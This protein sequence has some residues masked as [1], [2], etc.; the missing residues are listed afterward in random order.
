MPGLRRLLV[1]TGAAMA[2]H[3]LVL[4]WLQAQWREPEALRPMV[5]PLFTRQ[6]AAA[7]PPWSPT[8]TRQIKKSIK[9]RPLAPVRQQDIASDLIAT[10]V[11][12]EV[13]ESAPVSEA[14][15]EQDRPMPAADDTAS[16][17]PDTPGGHDTPV[18]TEPEP[19]PADTRLTYDLGGY[20]RGDLHGKARVQWQREDARYQVQVTLDFG[21]LLKLVMTSQ[22]E[23]TDDG[24]QP[25]AFE[26]TV[27]GRRRAVHLDAHGITLANGQTLPRPAQVQDA[28]SQFVELAWRF[29]T[30]RERLEEGHTVAL[31]MARPGG[32]DLWNYRIVGRET[33]YL[34]RLGEVEAFHLQPLPL[35]NPRGKITADIWFAP[36]LQYLPVRIR[37]S[38]D[39]TQFVDLLVD[40]IEQR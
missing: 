39:E 18:V 16:A 14:A 37:I 13:A 21:L 30:G 7:S 2:L 27:R 38:L 36:T 28:A 11:P 3:A 26:E 10:E 20:Y 19:W 6:I 5:A 32:V 25:S 17:M 12:D 24:L 4:G 34:G 35:A 22:G 1:L 15:A 9:K 33:L 8:T 29:Q 23:V 40:R 31:W